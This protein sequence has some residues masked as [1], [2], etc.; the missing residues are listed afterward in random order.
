MGF[1]M[2]IFLLLLYIT[3][4][5]YVEGFQVTEQVQVLSD[6]IPFDLNTF[7]KYIELHIGRQPKDRYLLFMKQYN[8]IVVWPSE[9][10]Q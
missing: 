1:C 2:F 8:S 6:L 5:L 3:E 7:K 9:S 10:F 4:K